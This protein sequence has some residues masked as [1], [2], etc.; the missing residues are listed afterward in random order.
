MHENEVARTQKILDFST[1]IFWLMYC[2]V[3][4][5]QYVY[6]GRHLSFEKKHLAKF[7]GMS[8]F[9]VLF[10]L[11]VTIWHSYYDNDVHTCNNLAQ[12]YCDN[13]VHTCRNNLAQCYYDNDVHTHQERSITDSHRPRQAQGILCDTFSKQKLFR[14]QRCFRSDQ[15]H[16]CSHVAK[17]FPMIGNKNNPSDDTLRRYLTTINVNQALETFN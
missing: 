10:T 12:C 14:F 15:L 9:K 3:W 2:H 7:F 11:V 16:P 13:G 17:Q 1:G 4:K 8:L 6:F 5:I